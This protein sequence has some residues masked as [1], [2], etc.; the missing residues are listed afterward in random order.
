MSEASLQRQ[1]ANRYTLSGPLTFATVPAVYREAGSAFLGD[2]ETGR[3]VELSLDSVGRC[4]SAGLALLL[5]WLRMARERGVELRLSGL[6]VQL[7]DL[8]RVSDLDEV[9]EGLRPA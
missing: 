2:A 5:E 6:P 1:S 3:P 4:D 9:L 8:M 7:E